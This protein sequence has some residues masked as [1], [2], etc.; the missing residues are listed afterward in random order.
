MRISLIVL[1]FALLVLGCKRTDKNDKTNPDST[2]IR[3]SLQTGLKLPDEVLEEAPEWFESLPEKDSYIYAVGVAK[4]RSGSIAS[5]K[6]LLK[7]QLSLA[8]KLKE[9][10][11]ASNMEDHEQ[12]L[13]ADSDPSN[14]NLA[15][16][17][18]DVIVKNK[19]QIKWGDLWYSFVLLEVKTDKK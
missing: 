2:A 1:L 17:M 14:D 5:N 7:A 11:P 8:E 19:K 12:P 10:K 3:D 15:I 9:I 16:T 13:G 4:S 18:Q 6:A